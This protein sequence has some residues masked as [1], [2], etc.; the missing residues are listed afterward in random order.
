MSTDALPAAAEPARLTAALRSAGALGRGHVRDV[1]VESARN[2]ILS[3]I[4]RL[5]LSYEGDAAGAPR[6]L[7]FKTGLPERL[8]AEW[9]GGR[10]EV[11]FY[12]RI[13]GA[14]AAPLTPRCF[15]AAWDGETNAWHLLLE[16]LTDT[17]QVATEWPIPPMVADSRRM[18]AALARFHAAWWDDPRLGVS[19]GTWQD[20]GEAQLKAF[21]DKFAQ[22]AD[23]LGDRMSPERRETY[24]QLIAAGP[25]LNARYRTHRNMTIL[26]GDAH[27]W[28]VFVPRDEASD[29]VRYF[30]WDSWRLDVATDDLAYMMALHWYPEHRRRCER[31]LLDRYHTELLAHGV[32]GYDRRALDDD[33]RLSVLWQMTT[34]VWQA[35]IKIPPWVWWPHLERIFAAIDDLGCR[36]LL[37]G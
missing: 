11:A 33:Y 24:E 34:P 30:D 26:H 8:N 27:I 37:A 21:A 10:D 13:A 1:A 3:R 14:M 17:H 31:A 25:R 5:R 23:R 20:P 35:A 32:A 28:N 6:S 16:D 19:I 2:T 9:R 15:D 18:I 22:F 29:D 4:I 7:I 36:E 12:Q